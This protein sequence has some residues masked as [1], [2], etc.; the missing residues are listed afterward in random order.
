MLLQTTGRLDNAR[1]GNKKGSIETE[2]KNTLPEMDRAVK[3]T[4]KLLLVK[5][6]NS[7]VRSLVHLP[8]L[9]AEPKSHIEVFAV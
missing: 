1:E 4:G 9:S 3:C 2:K 7:M 5:E 6:I 8:F